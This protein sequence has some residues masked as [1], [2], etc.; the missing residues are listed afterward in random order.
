[1]LSLI[2]AAAAAAAPA[3]A[4]WVELA[5]GGSVVRIMTPDT[6]CPVVTVDGHARRS[7]LRAAPATL[8]ER[9]NKAAVT[10]PIA[11]PT[12][13]CELPLSRR[14]HNAAIAGRP[15]PL[16]R[17]RIDRVLLI[18]DTGCRLKASEDFWQACNDPAQWPFAAIAARAAKLHPDLVLHV[19]DYLYR[20][21]PCPAGNAG[22]AGTAWGYGEAGW[23]ADFLDPAAPLLRVAPWIMV[24]G[25]H[26]E[27]A[28]AG[29]GWWRLLDPHALHGGTDCN[30]A[31]DD[32]VGNHGAPYAVALGGG[33]QILVADLVTASSGKR[34]D[35]AIT[36]AL[37]DDIAQINRMASHGGTSFVTA[38][39]PFNPVLWADKAQAGVSFAGKPLAS[40][41]TPPLTHVRAML[42]GHIHLF[43]YARFTDRPTQI[44]T[45]FSGTSEDSPIAP[46][47]MA[48]LAAKSGADP[49]RALTTITGRFGYALLQRQGKAWRM[50]VYAADG[51]VMGRFSV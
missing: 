31:A 49:I 34:D 23:R 19:G 39:F 33:A 11:F 22:C 35:P 28:R 13:V 29:Q 10:G 14:V 38:H 1:M 30:A 45:G 3:P 50:T 36:G 6:T 37:A 7:T 25:N 48:A 32:T 12:R 43:Q 15:L 20:E 8:P 40:F 44:I 2:L 16:P 4:A 46:A 17:A 5:P 21:N 47:D 18:G 51:S 41:T 42:A 26:E 9:A 27:C 24:R